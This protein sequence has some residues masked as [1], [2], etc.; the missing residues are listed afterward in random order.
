MCV[1]V[2]LFFKRSF[3]FR[4][5]CVHVLC[6]LRV[7]LLCVLRVCVWAIA[8]MCMCMYAGDG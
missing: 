8:F 6:V 2:C 5:L 1:W 7:C 4:C 3:F